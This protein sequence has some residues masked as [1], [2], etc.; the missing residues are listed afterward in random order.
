MRIRRK[1]VAVALLLVAGALPAAGAVGL[2]V[3]VST[4]EGPQNEPAIAVDPNDDRVLVAGSNSFDEGLTRVYSSADGGNSWSAGTLYPKP[5]DRERSCAADPGVGIDL[6]GRQYFSYIRAT[7]CDASAGQVRPRLYVSSRVG[8]TVPW[9]KPVQVAPL[10]GARGDDKP[11]M[12]IDTSPSSPFTNRVY[13]AWT[14][15]ARNTR[16][17]ILLSRSDDGGKTWSK[18]VKVNRTGKEL[19][20][21]TLAASRNG[22]LYVAWE[23]VENFHVVIT[24]STDGGRTFETERVAAAAVNVT[25]PSCGTGVPIPALR[26]RCARSN[27][28]LVVDRS[29]SRHRGRVYMTYVQTQLYGAQSVRLTVLDARLKTLMGYPLT[30]LG[31]PVADVGTAKR[32]Q[33]W[34]HAAVD[35]TTGA[36]WVCFYDTKGDPA[37]K[38]TRFSCSASLDGGTTFA[39]PVAVASVPSDATGENSDLRGYGDYEGLVAQNGVAYPIW[40][41]T[42]HN[43]THSTEIY[44]ATLTLAAFRSSG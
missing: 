29:K 40:T 34:S 3:R 16:F 33:F 11:A 32:D 20:Y 7:P 15:I 22:T 10:G 18:P 30:R 2:E 36:L 13:V 23:D 9:S 31:V 44:T 21:V 26:F 14:R 38:R 5:A 25:I 39:R 42:R 17:S 27:P 8:P 41:D 12:T 37:R 1:V 28:I 35:A 6:L 43:S 4:L 24:R 19:T